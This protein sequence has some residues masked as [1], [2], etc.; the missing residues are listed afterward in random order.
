MLPPSKAGLHPTQP[1]TRKEKKV[2]NRFRQPTDVP[3]RHPIAC[4]MGRASLF[5]KANGKRERER[6]SCAEV[7]YLRLP[8]SSSRSTPS[9]YQFLLG[10]P[11]PP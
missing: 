6:T 2:E 8:I 4:K 10:P 5:S 11:P 1:K 9:T 3:N 7:E